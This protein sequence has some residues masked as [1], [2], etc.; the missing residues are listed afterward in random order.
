LNSSHSS[1]ERLPTDSCLVNAVSKLPSK[2]KEKS[3]AC[4]ALEEEDSSMTWCEDYDALKADRRASITRSRLREGKTLQWRSNK[5]YRNPHQ[6][7]PWWKANSKGRRAI[8]MSCRPCAERI[9]L[10]RRAFACEIICPM[11]LELGYDDD[12]SFQYFGNRWYHDSF[13]F[14][15][16]GDPFEDLS[17][18][19]EWKFSDEYDWI[20][21]DRCAK[22][23]KSRLGRRVPKI[24][25]KVSCKNKVVRTRKGSRV[26]FTAIESTGQAAKRLSHKHA[27]CKRVQWHRGQSDYAMQ[28]EEWWSQPESEPEP[29]SDAK[30]RYEEM[31]LALRASV[32]DLGFSG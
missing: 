6:E 5:H 14:T 25:K 31:D 26:L 1:K 15:D 23:A 8:Q 32:A 17:C 29:E 10:P 9:S 2:G 24:S 13:C 22:I 21:E 4:T 28:E 7:R 18:W 20:K 30:D 19:V 3:L 27:A 12:N 16:C 11:D